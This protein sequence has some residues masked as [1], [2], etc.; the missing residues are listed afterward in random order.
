MTMNL[1]SAGTLARTDPSLLDY[2]IEVRRVGSRDFIE[3]KQEP[4]H[5]YWFRDEIDSFEGEIGGNR[6]SQLSSLAEWGHAE[7]VDARRI[8]S[9]NLSDPGMNIVFVSS[10]TSKASGLGH[11]R[12]DREAMDLLIGIKGIGGLWQE[13]SFSKR[14]LALARLASANLCEVVGDAVR[15]T[16]PGEALALQLEQSDVFAFK[17]KQLAF[18]WKEETAFLSSSSAIA[19][20][21]AYQEI[22]E[23][24]ESVVPLILQDLQRTYSHW[25]DAL[26][27][28]TGEDPVLEADYGNIRSMTKSWLAWGRCVG[29]SV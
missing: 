28:I 19:E 4:Q 1:D 29:Y 6:P 23:M 20:H 2:K 15:I 21:D 16:P 3:E 22:I 8:L 24:G 11:A 25:F 5:V 13:T 7:F 12:R 27:A 26:E 17:F 10:G 14:H 18:R 9:P